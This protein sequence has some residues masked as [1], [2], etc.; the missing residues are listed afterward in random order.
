MAEDIGFFEQLTGSPV[1]E[2][3]VEDAR[4]AEAMANSRTSSA[5]QMG[6]G[7]TNAAAGLAKLF[8]KDG[9]SN[10]IKDVRTAKANGISV[11]ELQ[12]R[13]R[14]R[15]EMTGMNDD[16]SI[17]SRRK[18]AEMAARISNEEGDAA[19]LTRALS[20]LK[21]LDREDEEFSKLQADRKSQEGRDLKSSVMSG[22]GSDGK[23][24]SGT[25]GLDEND[26]PG[27][28]TEVNGQLVHRA[29]DEEFSLI[30]PNR[31]LPAGGKDSVALQL[32]R[33][34]GIGVIGKIKG[35]YGSAYTAL[36]KTDRVLSTLT[37]LFNEGGVGS[38]I[39][40]SG[41]L[42]SGIDNFTR[43]MNGVITAVAGTGAAR[44]SRAGSNPDGSVRS[45]DGREG[46]KKL[47]LDSA[48]QFSQLI[49]L[50]EGMLKTSAA[51][52]QHRA[53]VMEM[54]Y[55][56]ARLAEPSNRGLSDN[57]I[58]NA[59]ARIA[60][61]T[62]NPQVM[63]R[64]FLEMQTDA[65]RE[66]HHELRG[67][68]GS[69]GP[70]VSDEEINIAV[71]GKGYA[72][73]QAAKAKLFKKFNATQGDDGRVTFAEGGSIGNDLQPGEGINPEVVEENVNNMTD[74]DAANAL[75]L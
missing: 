12:S 71:V 27:L 37:D 63:M 5:N 21:S 8:R 32:K 46:L 52:Q 7:I 50:P 23:A 20:A 17:K 49:Q 9:M 36:D 75:G 22:Y 66:L 24:Q 62:S 61:D 72:E 54:A 73:Y 56:A 28:W 57:D 47:A 59:L 65:E 70:N 16:G 6:R 2:S 31:D 26:K 14:V 13:R 11:G 53:A 58:K 39:S 74:E 35:L 60:G 30:D 48:N 64:R 40:W 3:A 10:G 18:I 25:L 34:V 15:K 55:M 68:H 69:L 1:D 67:L 43:N 33:N 29:F 41:T 44:D 38:V 4:D 51:A 42:V 45:W 19:G